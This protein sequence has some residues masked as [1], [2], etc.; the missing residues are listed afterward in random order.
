MSRASRP[1]LASEIP[2]MFR[3][4]SLLLLQS[5]QLGGHDGVHGLADVRVKG[6][7]ALLERIRGHSASVLDGDNLGE[8]ADISELRQLL[9][10]EAGGSRELVADAEADAG[11]LGALQLKLAL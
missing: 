11:V 4:C 3:G 2:D 6:L 10:L 7:D 1:R 8:A 5:R 9:L